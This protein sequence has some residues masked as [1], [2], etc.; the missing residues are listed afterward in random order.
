MNLKGRMRG[1][2]FKEVVEAFRMMKTPL[3]E[4]A[5]V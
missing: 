3:V 1:E 4:V 2:N 5:F